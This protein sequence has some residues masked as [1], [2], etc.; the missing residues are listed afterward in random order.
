MTD[1]SEEVLTIALRVGQLQDQ[2]DALQTF[3]HLSPFDQRRYRSVTAELV[4]ERTV[5]EMLKLA[6]RVAELKG[7]AR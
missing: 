6:A 3:A 1:H 4:A 7:A 5:R 2:A